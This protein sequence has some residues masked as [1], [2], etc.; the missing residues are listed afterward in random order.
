MFETMD[1]AWNGLNSSQPPGA[2][3][4]PPVAIGSKIHRLH[5]NYR[6]GLEPKA[7]GMDIWSI[8][9]LVALM[10]GIMGWCVTP[11][12][13]GIY[14]FCEWKDGVNINWG[15]EMFF[16]LAVPFIWIFSIIEIVL[17]YHL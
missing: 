13:N 5:L 9:L 3:G 1:R 17:V 6:V 8:I 7:F 11:F 4:I 2:V 15:M 14:W 10:S 16:M 12:V